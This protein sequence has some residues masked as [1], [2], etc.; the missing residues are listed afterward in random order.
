M[1]YYKRVGIE[2]TAPGVGRGKELSL[3]VEDGVHPNPVAHRLTQTARDLL[4][5]GVPGW[6]PNLEATGREQPSFES[7]VVP[8]LIGMEPAGKDH[9]ALGNLLFMIS[10][11]HCAFG[12]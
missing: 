5:F 6:A 4:H 11:G 8:F 12:M 9:N 2:G 1:S 3:L 10:T 7:S